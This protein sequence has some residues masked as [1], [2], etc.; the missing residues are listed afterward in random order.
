MKAGAGVVGLK[1][2]R[3]KALRQTDNDLSGSSRAARQGLYGTA[4]AV[5]LT[6]KRLFSAF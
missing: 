1:R 3:K 6:R 2:V 5:P 4:E